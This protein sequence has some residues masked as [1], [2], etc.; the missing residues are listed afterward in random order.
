M[1]TSS[2]SV[3]SHERFRLSEAADP[4]TAW[5]APGYREAARRLLDLFELLPA[6]DDESRHGWWRILLALS[7]PEFSAADT[8]EEG[9]LALRRDPPGATQQLLEYLQETV[10]PVLIER[11][12]DLAQRHTLGASPEEWSAS[13]L[14]TDSR[15][16][17]VAQAV[18]RAFS[19]PPFSLLVSQLGHMRETELPGREFGRRWLEDIQS[20]AWTIMRCYVAEHVR[21]HRY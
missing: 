9:Q 10:L 7:C 3:P 18:Q 16:P 12:V 2:D 20:A 17:V 11:S 4:L 13:E 19:N 1:S 6:L 21:F 5:N 15:I 8:D 14:L